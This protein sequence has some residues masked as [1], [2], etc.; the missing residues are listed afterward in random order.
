MDWA[1]TVEE[2]E[3]Q[4]KHD[5]VK[6]SKDD[7]KLDSVMVCSCSDDGTLRVWRPTLV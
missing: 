1:T 4:Q 3:W 2:E 7:I 6:L 5:E